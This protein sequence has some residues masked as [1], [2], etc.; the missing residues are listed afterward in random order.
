MMMSIIVIT[1]I[2]DFGAK[3]GQNMYLSICQNVSFLAVSGVPRTNPAPNMGIEL[4][5]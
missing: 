2:K 4:G 5:F 1:N 3:K